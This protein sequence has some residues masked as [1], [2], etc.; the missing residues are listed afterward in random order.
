MNP[1]AQIQQPC[2]SPCAWT[3]LIVG[4]SICAAVFAVAILTLC[5]I[6]YCEQIPHLAAFL[7]IG[8]SII[9]AWIT[10]VITLLRCH[11]KSHEAP[12]TPTTVTTAPPATPK[13]IVVEPTEEPDPTATLDSSKLEEP[14]ATLETPVEEP[15]AAPAA[16]PESTAELELPPSPELE[17]IATRTKL[18]TIEIDEYIK[19]QLDPTLPTLNLPE[20][21]KDYRITDAWPSRRNGQPIWFVEITHVDNVCNSFRFRYEDNTWMLIAKWDSGWIYTKAEE[22]EEKAF[23]HTFAEKASLRRLS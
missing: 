3:Q 11:Y 19:E 21:Y 20:N 23:L 4:A 18:M 10:T 9:G 1:S 12:T 14:A 2:M 6:G 13:T 8:A 15:P 5:H 7:M 16:A 22:Q 17:K